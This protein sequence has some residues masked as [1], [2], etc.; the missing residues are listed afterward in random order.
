MD[1]ATELGLHSQEVLDD[2]IT[3]TGQN[4]IMERKQ[5]KIEKIRA[6]TNE[7]KP[8]RA[9][10]GKRGVGRGAARKTVGAYGV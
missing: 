5:R 6:M 3:I 1:L 7:L 4:S 9:S 8:E 2:G 10:G